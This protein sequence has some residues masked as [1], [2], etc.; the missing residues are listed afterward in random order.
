[1][2]FIRQLFLS[3]LLILG[4][5]HI[6]GDVLVA[7]S[8]DEINQ[9]FETFLSETFQ[10]DYN[11]ENPPDVMDYYKGLDLLKG[12]TNDTLL[13][14]FY[15]IFIQGFADN[16]QYDMVLQTGKKG[17]PYAKK[18]KYY[19]YVTI[20]YKLM[21]DAYIEKND[22]DSLKR[23]NRELINYYEDQPTHPF[24]LSAYNNAGIYFFTY[25][26]EYDLAMS[27]FKKVYSF[28][29]E[30][31]DGYEILQG[32][33]FDNIALIH[34]EREEYSK[35]RD[36][37]SENYGFYQKYFDEERWMRAGIQWA[38]AE[39]KMGNL[40]FAGAFLPEIEVKMDSLGEYYNKEQNEILIARTWEDYYLKQGDYEESY[41]Y[42]TKAHTL[43]DSVANVNKDVKFSYFSRLKDIAL[44]RSK[45]FYLQE[46]QLRLEQQER[47]R[48]IY[49]LLIL[50]LGS[51]GLLIFTLISRFRHSVRQA[52]SAR[53]LEEE[54]ANNEQLKNQLLASEIDAKKQDLIDFALNISY[55][56]KWAKELLVQLENI[57]K[58]TGR[59]KNIAF[60]QLE[61]EIFNKVKAEK[62]IIAFNDRVHHLSNEFYQK[63]K[64][65]FPHLTK[66][67]IKLCSLIRL[68]IDNSEIAMMQNIVLTSVYQNRSRLRH[69]LG[70]SADDDLDGFIKSL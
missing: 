1:M 58:C 65:Q 54:R 56:Q 57:K 41:S 3:C 48:L 7:Q 49:W 66:S 8:T 69:Q 2:M 40:N 70:L 55:N 16:H 34:M 47:S 15:L 5:S 63:L 62:S 31:Y 37:F 28:P 19:S 68:G 67:E 23:I 11:R 45:N 29:K 20:I 6:S 9:R 33:M 42:A 64:T 44:E 24:K 30:K 27:Y 22:L 13:N 39:I 25:F 4:F 17:L 26:K 21:S 38:G 50:I 18:L 52:R 10:K 60:E 61:T 53:I 14:T 59:S 51:L 32:S 35:A 43:I 36:L 46:K 12:V